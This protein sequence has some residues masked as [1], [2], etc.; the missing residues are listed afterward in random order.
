MWSAVENSLSPITAC[1]SYILACCKHRYS[2]STDVT[3]FWSPI[4][5]SLTV[6][7]LRVPMRGVRDLYL[8]GKYA[9]RSFLEEASLRLRTRL[10]YS[11][12]RLLKI[13]TPIGLLIPLRRKFLGDMSLPF[14]GPWKCSSPRSTYILLANN[15]GLVVPDK[16]TKSMRASAHLILVTQTKQ[17]SSFEIIRVHDQ[18]D[19]RGFGVI[20]TTW[21]ESFKRIRI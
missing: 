17:F 2:F 7:V 3:V 20:P 5:A 12:W 18:N 8:R 11:S 9:I 13:S 21:D 15:V 4:T 10:P 14:N 1:I 19:F 6:I 16:T